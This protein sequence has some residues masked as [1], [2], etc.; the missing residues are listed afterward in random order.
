MTNTTDKMNLQQMKTLLNSGFFHY[1][2]NE[3][4][5]SFV[6]SPSSPSRTSPQ[7]VSTSLSFFNR[8]K[9]KCSFDFGLSGTKTK[10]STEIISTP[11]QVPE[12]PATVH[13]PAR[14]KEDSSQPF[15]IS[16]SPIDISFQH[17]HSPSALSTRKMK[18]LVISS[19]LDA[20]L[21]H[22]D[23][24]EPYTNPPPSPLF[25]ETKI[26][27]I[28][29]SHFPHSPR[30]QSFTPSLHSCSPTSR[31][32]SPSSSDTSSA[33]ADAIMEGEPLLKS[34]PLPPRLGKR[35]FTT[36]NDRDVSSEMSKTKPEALQGN[37]LPS[38]TVPS[39]PAGLWRGKTRSPLPRQEF[40]TRMR[41]NTVLPLVDKHPNPLE[42]SLLFPC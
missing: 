20:L 3:K 18:S 1:N 12:D 30:S 36:S 38:L 37:R 5:S 42:V 33:S 23:N 29:P 21:N 27:P 26:T 28:L 8:H 41:R 10:S 31:I 39:P 32:E 15:F 17:S 34:L 6:K 14:S 4:P 19:N 22:E 7:S 35:R 11:I 9:R 2:T 13:S 25:D 40:Q 16:P 24:Y